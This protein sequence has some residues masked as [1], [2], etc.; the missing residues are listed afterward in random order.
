MTIWQAGVTDVLWSFDD[1]VG[2]V[3]EWEANQKEAS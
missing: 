1:M 3:D 2:I